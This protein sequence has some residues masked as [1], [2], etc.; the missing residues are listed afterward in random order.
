MYDLG[1]KEVVLIDF[2]NV[3]E[4]NLQYADDYNHKGRS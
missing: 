3:I 2:S 4:I 1:K